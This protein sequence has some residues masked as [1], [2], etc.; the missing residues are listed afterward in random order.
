[1]LD[2]RDTLA[3][4]AHLRKKRPNYMTALPHMTPHLIAALSLLAMPT[5]SF[6]LEEIKQMTFW[7][8]P[9]RWISGE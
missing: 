7:R 6:R 1:M 5:A 2:W 4:A 3:V 8:L 9:A